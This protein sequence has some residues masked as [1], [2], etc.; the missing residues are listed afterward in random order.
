MVIIIL[1]ILIG[2]FGYYYLMYPD[3]K[4]ENVIYIFL[5]A[6]W[7]LFPAIRNENVGTDTYNYIDFF[8][9]PLSGYN[10]RDHVEIAFEYWN[11]IIYFISSNKY[12]YLFSSAILATTIKLYI[13][14]RLSRKSLLALFYMSTMA[15]LEPFLV[16]DY[17][18]MRQSISIS[19][20]LLFFY[21]LFSKQKWY[22]SILWG[23]LSFNFHNS[24]LFP[25]F[26]TILLYFIKKQFSRKTYLLLIVVSFALGNT[27]VVYLQ[28]LFLY[29][30]YYIGIG[31]M[32]YFENIGQIELVTGY[33][34]FRNMLPI[35]L[36]GVFIIYSNK[37]EE[38]NS[39]TN[40]VALFGIVATNV[41][42]TIP[43]GQR[44][45]FAFIPILCVALSNC[46]K[47]KNFVYILPAV[48]FEFYRLYSFYEIQNSGVQKLGNGNVI[49]P[50]ETFLW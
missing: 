7:C 9:H 23:L 15:F 24:S 22:Y 18:L 4:K 43:I 44:I 34:Y 28:D 11:R 25:I 42:I 48:L 49:F 1:V 50:Y 14:N 32:I 41:L 13:L 37:S 21:A 17:G 27:A 8:L 31:Q 12:W 20:Y 35:C 3:K 36:Y 10:G 33:E 26:A 38:L 16:T 5:C 39:F 19:F 30:S 29:L 2:L 45:T 40:K 47:K 46:M 6:F